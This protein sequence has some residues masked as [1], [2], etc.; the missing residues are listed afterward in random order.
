MLGTVGVVVWSFFNEINVIIGDL[1]LL[2][3][4]NVTCKKLCERIGC[5]QS[6]Y[7]DGVKGVWAAY[8]G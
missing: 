4:P 2:E 6:A 7:S 3:W 1:A 8:L 5:E